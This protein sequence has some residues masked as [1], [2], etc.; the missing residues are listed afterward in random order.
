[1]NDFEYEYL[2]NQF[3]SKLIKS[4]YEGWQSEKYHTGHEE[5]VKAC[6]S[7]LST[8][9]H[10]DASHPIENIPTMDIRLLEDIAFEGGQ[11]P[12]LR[13]QAQCVLFL[14]FRNLYDYAERVQMPPE[15]GRREKSEILQAY[16]INRLLEEVEESTVQMW[17]RIEIAVSE[18]NKA[19]SIET[20]DNIVK[21]IYRTERKC[22]K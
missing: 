11:M 9:H 2:Q 19:P 15:Q 3:R 17:K 21:A 6:M 12:D 7:I 14:A 10:H 18:Y 5:G 13:S 4:P 8:T 1:M 16:K 22:F 20:A